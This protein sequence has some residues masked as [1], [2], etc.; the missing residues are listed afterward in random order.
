VLALPSQ[1]PGT[2]DR[3]DLS[4]EALDRAAWTIDRSGRKLNG[5]AAI[6]RTLAALGGGFRLIAALSRLPGVGWVE[7]RVYRWVA[8]HRQYFRRLSV[9]P[10]CDRPGVHCE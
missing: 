6:N 3:F 2:T 1:V 8:G 4:R 9:T 7:D 5:A 10:E